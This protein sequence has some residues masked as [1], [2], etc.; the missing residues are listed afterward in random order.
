MNRPKYEAHTDIDLRYVG[1]EGYAF[2]T[3]ARITEIDGRDAVGYI[4]DYRYKW[5]ARL[6]AL[7]LNILARWEVPDDYDYQLKPQKP[8]AAD[9]EWASK[10]SE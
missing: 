9:M 3:V 2:P 4:L 6:V 10:E 5:V 8:T 1:G 7:L